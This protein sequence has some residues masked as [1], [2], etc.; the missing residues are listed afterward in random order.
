MTPEKAA[1]GVRQAGEVLAAKAGLDF[2]GGR[3]RWLGHFLARVDVADTEWARLLVGEEPEAFA[4]LCDAATV[5]ESYFFREPA[6]LDLLRRKVIPDLGRRPGRIGVWS[7]GCA[8]G[9]EAHTLG[10]MLF[11][12]G[13]ADRADVLGT[14]IA[15]SAVRAAR[16]ASYTRW[17]M[18]GV[19]EQTL[20]MRF[21]QEGASFGVV[22]ER[23]TDVTF[24]RHNLLSP[25]PPSGGPFH[26]VLCRNVLIY[27]TSGA[28]QH[29]G[30]L[31]AES[32][33]PG[34]WLVTGVSDP[35]LWR[36]PGLE[37]VA[38]SGG[39]VYRRAAGDRSSTV[40]PAVTTVRPPGQGT[41]A[42]Q[43]GIL[44]RRWSRPGGEVEAGPAARPP[45]LA[46]DWQARAERALLEARHG[47]CERL[48]RAALEVDARSAIG[49]SL[50]V[51]ALASGGDH[52]EALSAATIA[53]GRVGHDSEL[54]GLHA[55]LLL[56]EHRLEEAQV[57]ARQ[58]LYLDPDNALAHVVLARASDLLGDAGTAA[59][60]SRN[61]QRILGRKALDA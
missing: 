35:S 58:A 17:S 51:R 23:C 33:A 28:V 19:D 21:R 32:L 52:F 25:S 48:A 18:R 59:R 53:V 47:E 27:L 9:E 24:E 54:R 41:S 39:T 50:L 5:R 43:T 6:T 36:V 57:A 38:G 44:D 37:P 29:V 7:A 46:R 11:D 60:A 34:G 55:V 31:L 12:A 13:L 26:L 14:D 45:R 2:S 49:H 1:V 22:T 42:G 20:A 40:V 4:A 15:P 16:T 10:M 8:A 56:D 30:A 3:G 61:G